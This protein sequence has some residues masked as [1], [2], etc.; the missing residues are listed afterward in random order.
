LNAGLLYWQLRKQKIFT[1]QPGWS[2]FLVRLVVSVLVM[3]AALLGMMHV[4]PEWSLGTMPYRLLRL[5]AV[6]VV[7]I[8]AYFAT[9][10]ILGF[11]IKEF[12][13]RTAS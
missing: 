2:K 3:A 10:A 11:R 9:L 6:V 8:V 13:R 5:L 12:A 4:M 1:P 7:G